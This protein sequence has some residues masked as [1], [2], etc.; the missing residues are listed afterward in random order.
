[1]RI[2]RFA[3][4]GLVGFVV[5]TVA[6]AAAAQSL[7]PVSPDMLGKAAVACIQVADDGTVS[8]AFLIESTGDR[9]LDGEMVSWV[10]KLRWDPAKSSGGNRGDW[11]PMVL[12]FGQVTPPPAPSTCAPMPAPSSANKS[13]S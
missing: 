7:P 3:S 4:R 1:M 2:L 13:R 11:F 9:V 8:D 6:A 5:A 10:K 12:A